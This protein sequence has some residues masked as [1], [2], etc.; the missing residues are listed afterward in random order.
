MREISAERDMISA[1]R[2]STAVKLQAIGPARLLVIGEEDTVL[3]ESEIFVALAKC[4]ERPDASA[5]I[6]ELASRFPAAEVKSAFDTLAALGVT[7]STPAAANPFASAYWDSVGLTLPDPASIRIDCQLP[8]GDGWLR[9]AF[10]ANGLRIEDEARRCVVVAADYLDPA[11][12]AVHEREPEWLLAKPVGHTLWLGPLFVQGRTVCWRCLAQ[13]LRANRWLLAALGGQD[14]EYG[15]Q[16]PSRAMLPSTL[17][18]TA[19]L[20]GTVAAGWLARGEYSELENTIHTLDTRTLQ[21]NTH[22]VRPAAGCSTCR[23]ATPPGGA[24]SLYAL[25]SPICGIV[26]H[27]ACSAEAFA[28]YFCARAQL[29]PPL[30][31]SGA[32]PV[33]RGISVGGR[34]ATAA[35]AKQA[36]IG[37][38]VERY[39]AIFQ[40]N[41]P[42]RMARV[43]ELGDAMVPPAEIFQFS[44]AQYRD[45][46]EWNLRLPDGHLVPHAM[47][48]GG[49]IEWSEVTSLLDGSRKYVPSA[50]CYLW[51]QSPRHSPIYWAD[52]N[53]CAAGPTREAAALA[54][55]LELIERDALAI[56]WDNRVRRPA[57]DL[58]ALKSVPLTACRHALFQRDREMQLLDITTDLGVPVCVAVAARR[59]GSEPYFATAAALDAVSAARK[60]AG[61]LASIVFRDG[62]RTPGPYDQWVHQ[63]HLQKEPYLAAESC[64]DPPPAL[65]PLSAEEG[66]ERCISALSSGALEPLL[67]DLTRPEIGI[68]AVRAVVP[69]LRHHWGR[70]APGRLYEVPVRQGWRSRPALECELNP[71]VCML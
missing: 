31:V 68:P 19:G 65:G 50:Y 33:L 42:L 56:W 48:P 43:E 44:D 7:Q 47:D 10:E 53:G 55:L 16:Q 52:T 38:A 34:G 8:C 51:Y 11:L 21:W 15:P 25:V 58:A 23:P 1:M 29:A 70:Y 27:L 6:L 60:A 32:R 24:E 30:P 45:R 54:A 69:G 71:T 64:S 57:W 14:A 3:L 67:L 39:S 20:L 61:E 22:R 49:A 4:L 62:A 26:S 35:E 59:D 40:G 66:L 36:C 5:E 63:A 18:T 17:F 41:E 12:E 9:G 46:A 13:W 37:E 28:S 2:L